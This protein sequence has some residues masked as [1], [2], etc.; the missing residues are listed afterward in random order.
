MEKVGHFVHAR[1]LQQPVPVWKS[2]R[3]WCLALY[4]TPIA[5]LRIPDLTV[6]ALHHDQLCDGEGQGKSKDREDKIAMFDKL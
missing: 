6:F 4:G 2:D 3:K 1:A 5:K